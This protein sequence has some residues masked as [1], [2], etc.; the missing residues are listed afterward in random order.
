MAIII[1]VFHSS[2]CRK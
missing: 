1:T 2:G